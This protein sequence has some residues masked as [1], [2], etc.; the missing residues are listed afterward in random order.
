MLTACKKNAPEIATIL[1]SV[2]TSD[3]V[4]KY[5]QYRILKGSHYCDKTS[6]TPFAGKSMSFN[7]K[8]DSSAMYSCTDPANQNDINKL[9]GFTEGSDNHKNSARIGWSWNN[10]ALQL[11]AYAYVDGERISEHISAV[12]I[13]V[14]ISISISIN[15]NKYLL[16]WMK[17]RLV[18]PGLLAIVLFPVTGNILILAGMKQHHMIFLFTWK[19]WKNK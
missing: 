6:I 5:I 7:V 14:P 13:D 1:P 4:T 8:F 3:T 18:C 2:F 16:R 19:S 15:E 10:N 17:K 12:S 11:Y 9:V